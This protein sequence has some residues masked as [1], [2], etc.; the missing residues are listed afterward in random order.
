MKKSLILTS[1]LVG[2]LS[3]SGCGSDSDSDTPTT[4]SDSSTDNSTN[5]TD[6]STTETTGSTTG[7]TTTPTGLTISPVTTKVVCDPSAI[8][9]TEGSYDIKYAADGDITV[10]CKTAGQYTYG[11][12]SL[13]A[14][15]NQLT[16]TDLKRVEEYY[17]KTTKTSGSGIDTY[18]YKLGTVHHTI[19]VVS[20]GTPYKYNCI[21]TFPSPL[22]AT[23]TT[24]ATSIENLIDWEGDENNLIT[25]TCPK[26]YYDDTGDDGT[27]DTLGAG[28][29]NSI[30]NYTLT[31]SNGKRHLLTFTG[32][33]SFTK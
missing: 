7:T 4:G 30:I 15:I 8:S 1:L 25:T 3:F 16:I 28:T 24:D 14:G 21:E 31:D 23:L 9:S 32:S 13:L 26:S 6:S 17:L 11:E 22:P 18:D 2:V 33:Y 19:D 29:V 5:G 27:E 20:E 12:Y 10:M